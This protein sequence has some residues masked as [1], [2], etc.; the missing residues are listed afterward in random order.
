MEVAGSFDSFCRIALGRDPR[1]G[2]DEGV[3][4][5]HDSRCRARYL[6]AGA[7]GHATLAHYVVQL[8][9]SAGCWIPPEQHA[10]PG[11]SRTWRRWRFLRYWSAVRVDRLHWARV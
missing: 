4:A 1:A 2:C 8:C 3:E 9:A 10:G 7:A 5:V 6:D 11:N